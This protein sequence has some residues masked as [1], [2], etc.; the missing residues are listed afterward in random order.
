VEEAL[1]DLIKAVTQVVKRISKLI[2]VMIE[3]EK[4]P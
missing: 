3:E 1:I 2:D 4:R